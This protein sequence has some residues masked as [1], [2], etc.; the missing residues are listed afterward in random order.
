MTAPRPVLRWWGLPPYGRNEN[1]TENHPLA[2]KGDQLRTPDT[3]IDESFPKLMM[4]E[5][6]A[7]CVFD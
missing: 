1:K 4:M 2:R 5:V 6:F 7:S 3:G